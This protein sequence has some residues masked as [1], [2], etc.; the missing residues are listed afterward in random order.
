VIA[1][2]AEPA[3]A[4]A[5]ARAV[6]TALLESAER[7]AACGRTE[8][9]LHR[10]EAAARTACFAHGGLFADPRAERLAADVGLAAVPGNDA[11]RLAPTKNAA[12]IVERR[13]V[14]HV[15]T[16]VLP[17]GGHTRL[18]LH[19]AAN[20]PGC[21]HALALT[22][23]PAGT[24]PA[25]VEKAVRA[26]GGGLHQLDGSAPMLARARALRALADAH[27]D[28][29]VLHVHQ[30]DTVPLIAFAA[31][32]GAPVLFANHS[33]HTFWLGR[34][35]A[36]VVVSIRQFAHDLTVARRAPR[37][38]ALLPVPL[39]P[40]RTLPPRAEARA[41]LGVPDGAVVLMTMG[42]RYKFEPSATHD[43]FRTLGRVLAAHPRAWLHVVGMTPEQAAPLLP[44]DFPV[45]RLRCAGV[46]ADPSDH[47]AAA[48][49]YLENFPYGSYLGLLETAAL[50]V[51]PVLM[52]APIPQLRSHDDPGLREAAETHDE[53]EYV[54][55][56]GLLI[57]DPEARRRL[58]ERV[59]ADVVCHH[60][61]AGWRAT[62][63]AIYTEADC[64]GHAGWTS[65]TITPRGDPADVDR[66]RWDAVA[67]A[68]H[69]LVT[70][71]ARV[72]PGWGSWRGW[73]CCRFARGTRGSRATTRA[74]GARS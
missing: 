55:Y 40:G 11:T 5:R 60:L 7:L 46:L 73:P 35:V 3:A 63:E 49:L 14:L 59:R 42:T 62:L 69:P 34:G 64:L 57:D 17:T 66:A 10:L 31:G 39:R 25:F 67:F 2:N 53:A 8:A 51:P 27:A 58:G 19:W 45:A 26:A 52:Y 44:P 32:G 21:T 56:V 1:G 16:R 9:A 41:R 54:A 74:P 29:V 30:F 47:Q 12:G 23:Q 70:I 43:F 37:C 13:R 15:A 68:G 24:V 4:L 38:A 20:D 6:Y 28:V 36:D 33:D 50:G 48:D 65:E 72:A 18:L 61:G 22:S 71:G